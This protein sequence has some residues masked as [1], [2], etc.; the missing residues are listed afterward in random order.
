MRRA[1]SLALAAA[2]AGLGGWWAWRTYF[3]G[4]RLSG[5]VIAPPRF[6][7]RVETPNMMLFVTALNSGGVPV[8]AK[9]FVN[10]RL[11]L[12]W[13]MGPDDFIFPDRD[14]SGTMTVR[15]SVN[16]H[17]KVGVLQ[18]GD[19]YGDHRHPVLSGD[20]AVDVVIDTEAE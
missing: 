15:V 12:D 17:G 13:T 11:P 3:G 8:A 9:R 19:L 7:K 16:G 4:F 10:P 18:K 1:L 14:W 2:L 6:V 20:R 5:T